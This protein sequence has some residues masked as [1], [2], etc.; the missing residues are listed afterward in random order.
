MNTILYPPEFNGE[1]DAMDKNLTLKNFVSTLEEARQ[2]EKSGNG[3]ISPEMLRGI[4]P[5]TPIGNGSPLNGISQ[6]AFHGNASHRSNG[7][8]VMLIVEDNTMIQCAI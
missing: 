6:Q 4:Q 3:H 5:S 7:E 8:Q 2:A 1:Y